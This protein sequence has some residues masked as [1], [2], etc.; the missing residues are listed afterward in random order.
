MFIILTRP[1]GTKIRINVNTIV[2][3]FAIKVVVIGGKNRDDTR[4]HLMDT[5]YVDVIETLDEVDQLIS[6]YT[7]IYK[8]I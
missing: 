3:Y 5:S 2:K 1:S 7:S 8:N 6:R 4:I